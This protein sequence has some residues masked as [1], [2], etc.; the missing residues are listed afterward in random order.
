MPSA[1]TRQVGWVV[2]AACAPSLL[3]LALV[4][5]F[6]QAGPADFTTLWNDET[7]YWNEAAA[8]IR[9][10]FDGGY[11]TVDEK[12]ARASFSRFGPH[13][14]A[15]AVLY[16]GI[17]RVTGWRS[18]SPYL[19]HLVLIPLCAG[20]WLWVTRHHRHRWAAG[21]L[22]ACFFPLLYYLPTGM[23]NPLHLGIAFLLAALVESRLPAAW[24]ISLA[25]ALMT[26]ACLTRPTW[27]LVLPAVMWGRT[28]GWWR[29]VLSFPLSAVL[30]IAAFI[31]V[32]RMAAPYPLTSWITAAVADPARGVVVLLGAAAAGAW[33]F[34]GPYESWIVTLL[35][36]EIAVALVAGVMLW[37][38]EPAERWR[39]EFAA[40]M[41]LPVLAAMFPAGDIASGR[42]FQ[43]L[44]PHFLA[45]LLVVAGAG[46]Q[47]LRIPALVHLALLPTV[48]PTYF[49]HHDG[50]WA[51][52]SQIQRFSD[53]VHDVVVFDDK[54]KSG[55]ENTILMHADS[56]Q[57]PL[58]GLPPGVAISF[59][60]DWEDQ[61]MPPRS[62]YVLLSE[63][64]EPQVR[65]RVALT[66]IADTPLGGVYRNEQHPT[67]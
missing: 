17:G 2:L 38:R 9:A 12:P 49:N 25:T 8:F 59:V 46:G 56:L 54:A 35:R 64:D 5:G 14:P 67:Q 28:P 43:I 45:A 47:W 15:F 63:R 4:A 61:S 19:I 13:G 33:A 52:P 30:F 18:Y 34:L 16:G 10:G 36:I 29:R 27:A 62:R 6:W 40:L 66:K 24:R 3:T 55:W 42:E 26:L 11:I 65:P 50:R 39:I 31:V 48:L 7:V 32:T 37:R 51:G 23:Q 58:V 57:P 1:N 22:V 60:L 53:A 41:V 21:L 44:A 20:S